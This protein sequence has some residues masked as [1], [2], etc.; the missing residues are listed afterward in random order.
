MSSNL[1]KLGRREFF[2]N[3]GA[4]GA[5]GMAT[6]VLGSTACGKKE[7]SKCDDVSSLN[8]ADKKLRESQDYEDHTSHAD[9]TCLGCTQYVAG[10][11]GQCGTCKVIKG[12]IHPKGWCKLWVKKT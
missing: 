11:E 7:P 9:Q 6:V 2:K 1:I 5:L 4:L 3:T 8:P 12:P 10:A